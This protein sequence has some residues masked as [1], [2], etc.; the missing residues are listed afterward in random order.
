MI[1][2]LLVSVAILTGIASY[3]TIVAARQYVATFRNQTPVTA[4]ENLT[5]TKSWV[6]VVVSAGLAVVVLWSLLTAP[7]IADYSLFSQVLIMATVAVFMASGMYLTVVDLR[8]MKLPTKAIYTALG[9]VVVLLSAVAIIESDY[10]RILHLAMGALI[11]WLAMFI[12][13]FIVPGGFGFGDVR[14]MLLTGALLG[15]LSLSSVF[16]GFMFAFVAM[17]VFY[18]PLMLLRLVSRKAKA[19]FGPWI[20]LGAYGTLVVSDILSSSLIHG[21][22]L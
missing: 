12:L 10:T 5:H 20:L 18:I 3:Y 22:L 21:G 8:T 19:P 9:I 17:S 2:W 15:W 16:F 6:A 7:E 14:L 1:T 11:S 4:R 13:W